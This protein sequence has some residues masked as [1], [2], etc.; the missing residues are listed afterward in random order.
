MQDNG[1]SVDLIHI[2]IHINRHYMDIKCLHLLYA[3]IFFQKCSLVAYIYVF[4]SE[5]P[6]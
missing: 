5:N 4:T 1:H 6:Q 2:D 3:S